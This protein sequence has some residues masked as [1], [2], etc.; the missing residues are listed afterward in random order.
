VITVKNG[1]AEVAVRPLFPETLPDAGLFT[2]YPELMRMAE[3]RGLKDHAPDE[4]Q[5]YL[6][7]QAPGVT[8]RTK[9]VVA[10][11]PN[12]TSPAPKI[13]KVETKDWLMVRIT[14]K[15]EVTEV[16][17]NLL[18]DGRIRHR[19][20]NADLGGWRT[21]A[22]ILALTYPEGGGAA[23]PWRWFVADGSYLRRDGRVELDSLSKAFV[24]KEKAEQG[25]EA[26]IQGQ[27]TYAI[28]LACEGARSIKV[29]GVA[30]ACSGNVALARRSSPSN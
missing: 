21:D 17:F 11:T 16:Y 5:P 9:F 30:K 26:S 10:L 12:G 27:P 28:R 25:V 1:D 15:G 24:V 2:D 19:N 13:E 3:G 29:D 14:Q 4:A 8:D 18:A 23:N 20:A 22:Y 6:R 7:L